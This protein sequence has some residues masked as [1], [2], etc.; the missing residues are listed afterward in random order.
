MCSWSQRGCRDL[1]MCRP[2]LGCSCAPGFTGFLCNVP[3]KHVSTAPSVAEVGYSE[4]TVVADVGTTNLKGL[5]VPLFY[6]VQ[7]KE[8]DDCDTWTDTEKHI[9]LPPLSSSIPVRAKLTGL[10]PGTNYRIR[11]VIIDQD[12]SSFQGFQVPSVTSQTMC[13]GL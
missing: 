12:G 13:E 4:L 5:G 10:K 9:M 2:L 1:V 11:I 8:V 7:Y 3:Y 6:K